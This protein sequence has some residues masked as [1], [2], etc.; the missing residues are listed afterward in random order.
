V[1]SPH[2]LPRGG[3]WAGTSPAPT[4]IRADPKS[5]APNPRQVPYRKLQTRMPVYMVAGVPPLPWL[6]LRGE[7]QMPDRLSREPDTRHVL[8][9]DRISAGGIAMAG[10][11]QEVIQRDKEVERRL[12]MV[13]AARD[14]R[15]RIGRVH[16]AFPEINALIREVREGTASR[17]E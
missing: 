7:L 16:G 4:A 6:T 10:R 11:K 1:P 8:E 5:Q 15:H 2:F 9:S 12:K 17:Y 13:G 3:T 14:V